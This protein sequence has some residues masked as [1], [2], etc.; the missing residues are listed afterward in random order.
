MSSITDILTVE[1]M[2]EFVLVTDPTGKRYHF[3]CMSSVETQAW[4]NA[5]GLLKAHQRSQPR[6]E[7][8]GGLGGEQATPP[9]LPRRGRT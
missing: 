5:I 2:N 7:G 8:Q 3:H 6:G 1:G 4:I 9:P